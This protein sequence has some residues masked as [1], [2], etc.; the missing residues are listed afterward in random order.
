MCLNNYWTPSYPSVVLSPLPFA[1]R[2]ILLDE[3]DP[4]RQ[5]CHTAHY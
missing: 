1:A 3:L 2:D 5:V 4:L